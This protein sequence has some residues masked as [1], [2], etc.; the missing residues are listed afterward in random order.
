MGS[1]QSSPSNLNI[2]KASEAV[3]A[4]KFSTV[5]ENYV[6][7]LADGKIL[8]LDGGGIRGMN[9]A[10]I[11]KYLMQFLKKEKE[12]ISSVFEYIVGTS[13]GGILALYLGLG[14]TPSECIELYETLK[15]SVFGSAAHKAVVE[16]IESGNVSNNYELAMK[17][18]TK[19]LEKVLKE[20]FGEETRMSAIENVK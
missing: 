20:T 4:E 6:K 2:S 3:P 15:N 9:E 18:N 5:D 14:H 17:K 11:I 1:N 8:C 19:N 16:C 12:K 10:I 13:T 7:N